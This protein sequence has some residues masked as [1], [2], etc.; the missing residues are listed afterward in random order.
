MTSD[1]SR[2]AHVVSDLEP[3]PIPLPWL[4]VALLRGRRLLIAFVLIGM[5]TGVVL[6][7]L[8]GTSYTATFSFIPQSTDATARS[9]LASLAGQFGISV[10]GLGGTPQ[11][12]QLYADLLKTRGVLTPIVRDSVRDPESGKR[13]PLPV[14]LKIEDPDPAVVVEKTIVALQRA[15]IS[16]NVATRTTGIVSVSVRTRS[17]EASRDIAQKL[18]DGLNRFNSAT[19]KS[20]AAEERRFTEGRLEA[21]KVALRAAED[22]L[23]QFLQANHQIGLASEP[24]FQRDRLQREVNLRQQVVV[25]LSQQYEDARIREVRDT[26][27]IT[28]IEQPTLPVL[29]DPRGRAITAIAFTMIFGFLG[30]VIVIAREGWLR[31]RR[32]APAD[33]SY[34]ML[35]GEW[36]NVR[37]TFRPS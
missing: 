14:F 9:G 5:V 28:V 24:A 6:A 4:L 7:L 23:Q 2:Q 25:G 29:Y 33:E 3:S 30:A 15:V 37:D 35:A 12:P 36:R 31:Q 27:V 10:G 19:R 16:A 13:V 26:P 11:P 32:R 22:A 21:A 34:G 1:A 17:A 8:K 20:Q 18:L